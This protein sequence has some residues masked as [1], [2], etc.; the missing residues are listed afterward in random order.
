MTKLNDPDQHRARDPDSI[1]HTSTPGLL[2]SEGWVST[3]EGR[4]LLPR[5]PTG[6]MAAEP[7]NGDHPGPSKGSGQQRLPVS[8]RFFNRPYA[9]RRDI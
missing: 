6:C 2:W 9:S 7:G 4:A 3:G 8:G 5:R 1:Q